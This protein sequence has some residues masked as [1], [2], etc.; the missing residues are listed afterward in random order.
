MKKYLYYVLAF[1]T[2]VGNIDR[3]LSI[4]D[5]INESSMTIQDVGNILR[6]LGTFALLSFIGWMYYNL[7]AKILALKKY[8]EER[9]EITIKS[10]KTHLQENLKEHNELG[11]ALKKL[12]ASTEIT[13]GKDE[14]ITEL[15]DK[16]K[17]DFAKVEEQ[18]NKE[19][20]KWC[21][22]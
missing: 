5:R 16:I 1:F 8:N 21:S 7:K 13:E 15:W 2:I 9:F 22:E 3:I 14:R 10:I 20:K 6:I 11:S 17:K 18:Y 12:N 19:F 4:I